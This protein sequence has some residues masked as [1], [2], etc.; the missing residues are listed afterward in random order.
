MNKNTI[1]GISTIAIVIAF[2]VIIYLSNENKESN[3]KIKELEEDKLKLILDSLRKRKDI[4]DEVKNQIKK[5]A[6]QFEK[7]DRKISN[8][9]I[10]ALQL[11]Q[12]GQVENA[13]EDLVKIIEHLLIKFYAS[14]E[15]FKKWC[16][17]KKEISNNQN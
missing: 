14:K 10:Q 4:S 13:I 2:F 3:K 6:K 1:I 8:E 12:I 5:L 7:I 9:L 11:F 15:V 17:E 16:K